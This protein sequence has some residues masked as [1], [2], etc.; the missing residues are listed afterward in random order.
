M[1]HR[2]SSIPPCSTIASIGDDEL[3]VPVMIADRI[4]IHVI[5]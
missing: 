5:A 3:T 2:F 4:D 1:I